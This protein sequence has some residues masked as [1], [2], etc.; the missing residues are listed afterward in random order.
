VRKAVRDT[1]WG[2]EPRYQHSGSAT[3]AWKFDPVVSSEAD[4]EKLRAPEVSHDT[5]ETDRLMNQAVDL[6]GDLLDVQLHGVRRAKVSLASQY[7]R[8][9]GLEEVMLDM[10]ENPEMLHRAMRILTDG[11]K[12]RFEQLRE[13]NL[14]SLNNNSQYHSSGGNGY[15]DELPAPGFD[16]EGVRFEDMWAAA[17]SQ[18]MAQVS[19]A[20]H[21]EFLMQYEREFLAPFGLAGYGCCEDLTLKL[22]GVFAAPN[23]RRI[24]ISPWADVA[25]CA[26]RLEDRYIFSW[27]PHPAH[28]VGEFNE[29]KIRAYIRSTLEATRG[30]V[31]E[32]I[33]K[34]THTCE[35][36]PERFTRWV[37]IAREEVDA[38]VA[39]T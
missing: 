33:L 28:L 7:C 35:G 26:E 12:R 13:M 36:R 3:G 32:M 8:L 2:L 34:D 6:F 30:C 16:G 22:D 14:L 19:P 27:K 11:H 17:E 20:M 23:M 18:E 31:V 9:R 29:Q 37:E 25:R 15:S 10:Y 38:A 24:S 39:T 4:L 21:E 5:A 1:G